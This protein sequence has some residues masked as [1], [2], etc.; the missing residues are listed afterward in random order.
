MTEKIRCPACGEVQDAEV[1]TT[2]IPWNTY[3]HD[4]VKCGY[5]VM[6]SDW[7]KVENAKASR[8]NPDTITTAKGEPRK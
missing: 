4:C 8:H 2:T 6:E 3:I 1:D 7:E 5:T